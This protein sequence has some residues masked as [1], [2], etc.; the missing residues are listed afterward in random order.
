MNAA[1]IRR[2]A[3]AQATLNGLTVTGIFSRTYAETFGMATTEPA[4]TMLE[5]VPPQAAVT[6]GSQIVIGQQTW[7]IRAVEP[8]GTGMLR[9]SLELAS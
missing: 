9:L 3:N 6:Q 8:D 5:P 4:F 7:R 2:L 1:V